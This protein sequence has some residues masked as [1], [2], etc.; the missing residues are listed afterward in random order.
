[1]TGISEVE[2][3]KV[4]KYLK[5]T[6]EFS[7]AIAEVSARNCGCDAAKEAGMEVS[8]EELQKVSD[9]FRVLNELTKADDFHEW[10]GQVAL[11]MDDYE[12]HL[13]NNLLI[14]KFKDKL[15]DEAGN[16]V[17]S[18]ADVQ[19]VIRETAYITW[20]SRKLG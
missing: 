4:I 10:L 8:D 2:F 16:E 13:L 3:H 18:S 14:G 6:G 17:L 7:K 15:Q 9:S 11:S 5:F 19:D 12:E 1:M 20:I